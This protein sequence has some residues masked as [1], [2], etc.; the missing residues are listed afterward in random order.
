MLSSPANAGIVLIFW[1]FS[2]PPV[3]SFPLST[4]HRSEAESL[5]EN[6]SLALRI[7]RLISVIIRWCCLCNE[8]KFWSCKKMWFYVAETSQIKYPSYRVHALSATFICNFIPFM[9]PHYAH[10]NFERCH[11]HQPA[12]PTANTIYLIVVHL[13]AD[14]T[15]L[16]VMSATDNVV[17]KLSHS[18]APCSHD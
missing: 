18:L 3:M 2:H 4:K 5:N 17:S 13:V 15:F 16:W 12:T 9:I 8:E 6:T 11:T 10:I 7:Y 1:H 14:F